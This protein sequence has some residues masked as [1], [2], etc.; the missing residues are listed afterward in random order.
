MG[1]VERAAEEE[2]HLSLAPAEEGG[3]QLVWAATV[4]AVEGKV[5]AVVCQ[6]LELAAAAAEGEGIGESLS[7]V[8]GMRRPSMALEVEVASYLEWEAWAAE[9][10]AWAAAEVERTSAQVVAAAGEVV[11]GV[12][13]AAVEAGAVLGPVRVVEA[14]APTAP[15]EAEGAVVEEAT[16][17]HRDRVGGEAA[18]QGPVAEAAGVAAQVVEAAYQKWA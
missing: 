18:P 13:V 6:R 10:A 16:V 2:A 4:G 3:T 14:R 7:E 8:E 1:S 12:T 5:A 15:E 17:P 11:L 9:A